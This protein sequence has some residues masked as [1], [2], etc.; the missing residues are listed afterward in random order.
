MST[1]YEKI[2]EELRRFAENPDQIYPDDDI[3]RL[4]TE[5]VSTV[6]KKQL[7]QQAPQRDRRAAVEALIDQAINAQDEATT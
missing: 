3:F 2:K 5:I 1:S 6:R 4:L 7:A